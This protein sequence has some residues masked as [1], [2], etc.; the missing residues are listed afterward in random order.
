MS[1]RG[2][3]GVAREKTRVTLASSASR[4]RLQVPPD[5]DQR[6]HRIES[7]KQR[8]I[9]LLSRYLRDRGEEVLL[10]VYRLGR[11]A[12]VN[13]MGLLGVAELHH[14]ALRDALSGSSKE[15]VRAEHY[16]LA[17]VVLSEFLSAHEMTSRG[18]REAS[19]AMRHLNEML[20]DEVRR[21]AHAI[22]DG[23]GQYLA[24]VH[25]SLYSIA[26][27]TS[28]EGKKEIK[29]AHELLEEL[30]KDLRRI[31]HELRP[32]VLENS[33]LGGAIDFLVDNVTKRT[34]LAIHIDNK[35]KQRPAPVVETALYRCV[36]EMLNNIVKHARAN[37]AWI[38]LEDL[39]D[40][41]RCEVRDDGV[42]F[43]A[44]EVVV[45]DGGHQLGF[46]GIQERLA[47]LGGSVEVE[48]QRGKG[49]RIVITI[50]A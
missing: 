45:R 50:P 15:E 18:Y 23:A 48:S 20:E 11:E 30:E 24:C 25:I 34:G 44:S 2:A 8:Y 43:D 6:L 38:S 19:T 12:I 4:N 27:H 13:E 5:D 7:I 47:V 21:I 3:E 14:E 31:S 16:G 29:H 17:G 28:E 42:G 1:R 22:H 39:G 36:Q 32:R 40:Q 10:D 49:V 37:N 41:V 33:G 35:L 26:K 46:L 9:A